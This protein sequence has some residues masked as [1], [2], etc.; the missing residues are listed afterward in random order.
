MQF[1][2]KLL[3]RKIDVKDLVPCGGQAQPKNN[4]YGIE[5]IETLGTHK[6]NNNS[7]KNATLFNNITI[8][9]GTLVKKS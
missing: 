8:L 6:E 2:V 1:N 9:G 4:H 7:D 3:K 5:T